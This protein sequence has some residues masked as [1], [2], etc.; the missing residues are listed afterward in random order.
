M[1]KPES[2]DGYIELVDQAIFEMGE[3]IACAGDEGDGEGEFVY[4]LPALQEI[5]KGLRAL[6][7][8]IMR[9]EHTV[10]GG[11]D[12]PFMPVVQRERTRIPVAPLIDTINLAYKKGFGGK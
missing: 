8:E 1:R 10:G 5:E 12:L 4:V 7:D 2:V 9:N 6:H 11:K 3:L